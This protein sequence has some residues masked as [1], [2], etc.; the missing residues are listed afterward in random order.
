MPVQIKQGGPQSTSVKTVHSSVQ[1]ALWLLCVNKDELETRQSDIR[2]LC[3]DSSPVPILIRF[4]S[5]AP[6][7]FKGKYPFEFEVYSGL[8]PTLSKFPVCS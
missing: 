1:T 7:W 3:S 2:L 6:A 8:V 5:F 4:K